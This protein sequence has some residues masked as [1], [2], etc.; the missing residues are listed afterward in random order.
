MT[1][2]TSNPVRVEASRSRWWALALICMCSLMIV[3]DSTVV[4]VALPAIQADLGFSAAGLAWVVNAYLLTF[5]GFMLLGGRLADLFG[6]RR[7]LLS[8]ITLFTTA[9]AV[10][11][12]ANDQATLTIARGIQG[13]GGAVVTAVALSIVLALFP[14]AKERAKAMSVWGF[15]GSGGATIGV[16]AG[17]VLTQSFN[18]HWVF[19]INLPIG[20]AALLFGP[21]LLPALAPQH[22]VRGIDW[23]GA[24]G[25]V[26]APVLA[27]YGI[28]TGGQ[29]GWH[30]GALGALAAAIVVGVALV[31]WERRVANPLMALHVFRSRTVAVSNL[32]T[33][34]SGAALFGWFFFAPLYVQHILGLGAL[35]T[36][37]TFLPATLTMGALSLGVTARLVNWVGP[38]APLV[39]GNVLFALGLALLSGGPVDCNVLFNVQL[40]MLVLGIGAGI[41]FMPLVLIATSD[42]RP[43]DGGMVSGLMSTSQMV[44]GAV[45][46]AVLAAVAA[47]WTNPLLASGIDLRHALNEGYHAAFQTAA[48]LAGLCVVLAAALLPSQVTPP[49]EGQ[50][51]SMH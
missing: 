11:G 5:G 4:N 6:R 43:E 45:G 34:L 26:A 30:L 39:A 31:V 23:P 24:I 9:S 37:L 29:E 22:G 16:V 20:G 51:V 10:C 21:R 32:V 1:V 46:L 38:K 33:V 44:G 28:V 8:G 19:L 17:G 27:V 35:E 41:S 15:V 13:I 14:E 18:W 42:A 47:A 40:P 49:P 48:A 50:P 12:L 25:V 7:V 2:M 36:G 3:L